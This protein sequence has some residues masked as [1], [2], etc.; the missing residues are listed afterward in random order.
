MFTS[1][2]E[3]TTGGKRDKDSYYFED[4]LKESAVANGFQTGIIT[5]NPMEGLIRFHCM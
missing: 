3:T 1:S 5:R 4:I 2:R